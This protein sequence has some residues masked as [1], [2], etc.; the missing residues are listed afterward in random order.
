MLT[1]INIVTENRFHKEIEF[2]DFGV[3]KFWQCFKYNV[4]K[5]LLLRLRHL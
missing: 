1:S 5:I 3:Y 2:A 4:R